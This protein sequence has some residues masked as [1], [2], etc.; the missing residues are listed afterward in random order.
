MISSS[1]FSWRFF[2]SSSSGTPMIWMLG[3][4]LPRST[5]L[6]FRF[7]GP[8]Q[9]HRLSWACVLCPSQVWA[10][11]V[12]R[13]LASTVSPGT[14][15]LITSLVS[16]AWF[17]GC[18]AGAPSHLCHVSPLGSWFLAATLVANVNCPGSQEDLVSNWESAH[19]LVGDAISG[20]KFARCLWTRLPLC[21]WRGMGQSTAS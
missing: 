11:Q 14:A 10:A 3:H 6:R 5:P 21:L 13:Y 4:A 16:A 17:P 18:T 8:P 1:I 7:L 12:T 19:N 2:L 20:A 9:R 15:H